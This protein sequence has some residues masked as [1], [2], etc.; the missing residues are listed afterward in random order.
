MIV[1]L[2]TFLSSSISESLKVFPGMS[3]NEIEE[4]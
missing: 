2:G 4:V 3:G 1:R